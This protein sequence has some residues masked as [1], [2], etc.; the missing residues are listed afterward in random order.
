M[1]HTKRDINTRYQSNGH[2]MVV[3]ERETERNA[4]NDDTRKH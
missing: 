1:T 3:F 4:N 2:L